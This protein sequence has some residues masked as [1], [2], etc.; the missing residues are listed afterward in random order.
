M[1]NINIKVTGKVAASPKDII[2]CGNSDYKIIFDFSDEWQEYDTKTARFVFNNTYIDVIFTGDTVQVPIITN[3][4]F[5]AVGVYAGD[6]CTTTPA[7]IDCKKSILC[8]HG[9]PAD[10][11]PDVYSQLITLLGDINAA[12]DK[13]LGV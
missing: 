13:I 2:V 5:V 7:L 1:N 12:L 3:T 11:A 6:L 4:L 8:E 10:P 9:T